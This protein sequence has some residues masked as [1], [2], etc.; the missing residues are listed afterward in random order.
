M[1]IKDIQALIKFVSRVGVD[2]VEL[3]KDNFKISIKKNQSSIHSLTEHPTAIPQT[4]QPAIPSPEVPKNID[5]ESEKEVAEENSKLYEFKSPMI[6]TFY[7]SPGPDKDPFVN[8]GDQISEGAIL[9]IVEAMKLFN[10]IESDVTGK[11]VKILVDDASP[12]EYGQPL[13]LIE[14]S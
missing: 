9:C 5:S 3:E 8:I 11:I 4:I 10:E 12:V 14:P 2:E 6:G 13:F 1:D 7:L